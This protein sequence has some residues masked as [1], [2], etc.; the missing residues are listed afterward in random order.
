[1]EE[2]EV[3]TMNCNEYRNMISNG[4]ESGDLKT[5]LLDCQDC[6]AYKINMDIFRSLSRRNGKDV[7]ESLDGKIISYAAGRTFRL[8]RRMV[9]R[10]ASAAAAASIAICAAASF[11]LTTLEDSSSPSYQEMEQVLDKFYSYGDYQT[12]NKR[13]N[14]TVSPVANQNSLELAMEQTILIR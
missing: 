4:L 11:Y 14:S 1:M 5:H 12:F 9:L 10:I 6:S 2:A 7:P 3:M 8:R 13:L